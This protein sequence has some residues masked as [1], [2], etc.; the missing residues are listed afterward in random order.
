MVNC[1]EFHAYYVSLV[2]HPLR[3][4]PIR[5]RHSLFL[6]PTGSADMGRE[7][8]YT[9]HSYEFC[10]TSLPQTGMQTR[11]C[12]WDESRAVRSIIV[13]ARKVA[14]FW[15][16]KNILIIQHRMSN[17]FTIT[18]KQRHNQAKYFEI[19][20]CHYCIGGE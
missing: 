14:V 18:P 5:T 2:P 7:T 1:Q 3:D 19:I 17:I 6:I 12:I 16:K 10:G 20:K 11:A 15:R 8:V 9:R 4:R 13:F